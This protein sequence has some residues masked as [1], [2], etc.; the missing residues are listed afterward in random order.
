MPVTKFETG[1]IRDTQDGK[2]D[3]GEYI[4]P[5]A[6]ARLY[7]H[8]QKNAKKYGAGNW[9][10]GIPTESAKQSKRRHDWV[11]EMEEYGVVL[12]PDSDHLAGAW[13]NIM[14]RLHNEEIEKLKKMKPGDL[15]YGYPLGSF[16]EDRCRNQRNHA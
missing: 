2:F 3:I 9:R 11:I 1:A 4:S 7:A 12:E 13:F 10:K 16:D 6:L 5:L 15:Y 14:Q 8:M